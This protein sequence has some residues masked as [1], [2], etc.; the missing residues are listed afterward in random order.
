[1]QRKKIIIGTRG[2]DLALIQTNIVE[3]LLKKKYPSLTITITI[4][5]TTGDNDMRPVPLDDIG[6]GWFTR[7]L[8][9]ALLSGSIDLA[10]HSLKDI[11]E[12]LPDG[13]VI[14]AV[15]KREDVRDAFVSKKNV[16]FA[17]LKKGA[18]IGTD[19]NRR[20]TQILSRRPDLIVNSIRGN[21]QTR[22]EK[23]NNGD[24]DGI[25]LAVAGL[26]RLGMDA[27]ISEYFPVSEIIPSPGQGA[28]AVVCKKN[29]R[30]LIDLLK[31]ITH[32]RTVREVLAEREFSQV[33]GGGCKT[34]VGAY[35]YIS[36]Q[37]LT[38]QGFIG[39]IDGKRLIRDSVTGDAAS[40][41]KLGRE[42]A[43]RL[44]EKSRDWYYATNKKYVVVTRPEEENEPLKRKLEESGFSVLSYPTIAIVKAVLSG[45]DK[46]ALFDIGSF[47]RIL[48]TSVHGVT[49]FMQTITHLKFDKK[50]LSQIRIGAVGPKTAEAAKKSGLSVTVIP[51]EFTTE[52]LGK[53]FQNIRGKKFLLLRSD[54]ASRILPDMLRKKG[55]QV[56]EIP[57]Y[58]T[59]YI[60]NSDS[61]F[62]KIL[63]S[64]Q[65]RCITF[66]SPSTVAG[67]I[68]RVRLKKHITRALSLPVVAIGPVTQKAAAKYGFKNISTANIYTIEGLVSA[69]KDVILP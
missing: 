56:L 63:N 7:E 52:A 69:V 34:P 30:E 43:S 8:D 31:K 36:K 33:F 13:L 51:Q 57:I 65:I 39:S 47:D 22:L 32:K 17:R 18:V 37:S 5:K 21:V 54:I 64:E 28:L 20:R 10:V 2:S 26:K 40:Y 38:L 48:F 3:V 55:A 4:I 60:K 35:A 59:V 42:L 50:M 6:K 19:S 14:A 44:L 61:M 27:R 41:K 12:T 45:K 68:K 53:S 23:L 16:P 67:F 1:M 29:N 46:K 49:Y 11:P 9:R 62:E 24:Y 58:K 25:I 66:T 15:L